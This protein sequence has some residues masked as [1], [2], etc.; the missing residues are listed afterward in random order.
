FAF[1]DAATAGAAHAARTGVGQFQPGAVRRVEHGRVALAHRESAPYAVDD[2]FDL[3]ALFS[4]FLRLC[5]AGTGWC[6]FARW[7]EAFEPDAVFLD[8]QLRQRG[9][10][11]V[12]HLAGTAQE[13]AI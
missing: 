1:G 7:R 2:N 3:N 5:R 4:S 13:D 12:D 8:A 6:G 9:S 10:D 11:I